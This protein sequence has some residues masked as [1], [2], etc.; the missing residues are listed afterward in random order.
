[1]TRRARN[2]DALIRPVVR[3]GVASSDKSGRM[4]RATRATHR[5]LHNRKISK[6]VHGCALSPTTRASQP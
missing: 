4:T 1:M 3:L 6:T 2:R 5:L